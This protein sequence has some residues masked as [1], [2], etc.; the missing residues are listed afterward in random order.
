MV[1]AYV[2]CRSLVFC[3]CDLLSV[4]QTAIEND[5]SPP[6][7]SLSLPLSLP[8]SPSLQPPVIRLYDL[9]VRLNAAVKSGVQLLL[10][11]QGE[12]PEMFKFEFS[13]RKET[14]E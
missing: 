8:L 12:Y 3:L 14:R 6:P 2:G 1:Y 7:S 13:T 4:S 9:H 5:N 11:E 10:L